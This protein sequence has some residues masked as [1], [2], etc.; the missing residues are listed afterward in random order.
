MH[1]ISCVFFFTLASLSLLVSCGS[2]ERDSYVL[3]PGKDS[4]VFS[5]NPQTSVFIKALFPYTDEKGNEFLTFQNN[6]E[7]QI[8]VYYMNTQ[9]Y[10]KSIALEREG[11]DGVGVFCGDYIQI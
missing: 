6:V 10:V 9:Q 5:L 3:Q 8:L 11:A 7:P 1:K 2:V 4:L